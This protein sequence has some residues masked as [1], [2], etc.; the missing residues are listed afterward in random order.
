MEV[1]IRR[2]QNKVAQY[3]ST[4][5]I[6]VLYMEAERHMGANVAKRWRSAGSAVCG[7]TGGGRDEGGGGIVGDQT[8]TSGKGITWN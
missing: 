2:R 5:P 1:Y 6:M 8:D 3:I 4:R 7:S